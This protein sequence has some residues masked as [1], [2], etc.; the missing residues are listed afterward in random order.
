M[1]RRTIESVGLTEA[2][3]RLAASL[4][5]AAENAAELAKVAPEAAPE[6][7][8][9]GVHLIE[10]SRAVTLAVELLSGDR[11]DGQPAGVVH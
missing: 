8:R 5:D 2:G 11:R 10:A 4:R 3:L 9:A 6:L 7:R 1:L